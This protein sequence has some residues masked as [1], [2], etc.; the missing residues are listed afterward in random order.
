LKHAGP[1]G[2][3][4]RARVVSSRA[5]VQGEWKVNLNQA[6]TKVERVEVQAGDTIDF[7]V[8]CFGDVNCDSFTWT[9]DLTLTSASGEAIAKIDAAKQFHGP[10]AAPW[11]MLA[12]YAWQ[13]VYQRSASA[14]EL[15]LASQ[16]VQQQLTTL[17]AQ[18]TTGDHELAAFTNLCQQLLSS[19]EFLY[20]D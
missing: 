6:P 20:V 5:G 17:A 18:K 9:L 11:P 4:V 15:A 8:D 19:N 1:S 12:A 2:D 14:E 13:T 16:F 7:V 3:G 10:T